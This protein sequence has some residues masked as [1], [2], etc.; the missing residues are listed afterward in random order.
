MTYKDGDK[1]GRINSAL[2]TIVLKIWPAHRKS[3]AIK[4]P[5][6]KNPSDFDEKRENQ[7]KLI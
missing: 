3:N 6:T 7:L 1:P 4:M 2:T 5:M